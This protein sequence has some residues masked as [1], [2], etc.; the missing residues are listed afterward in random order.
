MIRALTEIISFQ[1][2]GFNSVGHE[3]AYNN[4]KKLRANPGG[5]DIVLG[6]NLGKN[7]QTKEAHEDYVKGIYR[8]ADVADYFVVNVS[9]PNTPGLRNLQQKDD[10]KL[11]LSKVLSAR[12]SLKVA[13]KP[14]VLLKIAPDLTEGDVRD[15]VSVITSK[16]CRVDGLIISNTTIE[17]SESLKSEAKAETGGLSGRPLTQRSTELVAK[18]YKLTKGSIPI[19][20]V[21]GIFSGRDA[22][23]KIAAGASSVQLY[24]SMIC[25]GPPIIQKVKRELDEL[26]ESNG[27]ENVANAR[28]TKATE[29][30]K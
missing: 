19:I 14:P 28:G 16:G 23:D 7:K 25:H 18:F 20:G 2:Y 8:F 26:L 29:W 13:K 4:L 6:V 11:L 3:E 5:E 1:S 10:L 17:R 30:A 15:I 21:G 22:F 27:F 24:T 12:D 9:S